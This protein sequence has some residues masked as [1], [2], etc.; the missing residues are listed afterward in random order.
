MIII[1]IIIIIIII[2]IIVIIVIIFII[3]IIIIIIIIISTFLNLVGSRKVVYTLQSSWSRPEYPEQSRV[4][5]W[6]PGTLNRQ[7]VK[8]KGA[9][10]PLTVQLV[11]VQV[12]VS[13]AWVQP[14]WTNF[15][16]NYVLN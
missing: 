4:K 6:Y 15:S 12:E 7:T 14:T 2:I 3:F 9:W 5:Y 16:L 10:V 13:G 8:G 11:K 1:T